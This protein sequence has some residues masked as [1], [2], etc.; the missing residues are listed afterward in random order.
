MASNDNLFQN[1]LPLS[2]G[3]ENDQNDLENSFEDNFNDTMITI[4]K[5]PINEWIRLYDSI[6]KTVLKNTFHKYNIS[7]NSDSEKWFFLYELINYR[8]IMQFYTSFGSN[9][10]NINLDSN[11]ENDS[12]SENTLTTSIIINTTNT[13]TNSL[14]NTSQNNIFNPNRIL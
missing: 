8:E 9:I 6:P 4:E 10:L 14:N 3:G 7:G 13:L 2:K 5:P 1:D 11:S 12:F